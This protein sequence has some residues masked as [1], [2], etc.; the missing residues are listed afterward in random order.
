LLHG[1]NGHRVDGCLRRS[2]HCSRR[3]IGR[4]RSPNLRSG[5]TPRSS[6]EP[7]S[8]ACSRTRRHHFLDR[9]AAVRAES[10]VAAATVLS[11]ACRF[12]ES[13]RQSGRSVVGRRQLST[14]PTQPKLMTRTPRAGT[15]S[16]TDRPFNNIGKSKDGCLPKP[17][18]GY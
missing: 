7:T 2:T 11:T 4:R 18:S 5:S 6:G 16:K 12:E 8:L 17:L 3:K 14:S 10:R 15:R 1:G 9:G 13:H